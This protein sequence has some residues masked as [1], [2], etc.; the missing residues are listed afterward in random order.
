MR[1]GAIVSS[2]LHCFPHSLQYVKCAVG[3][4]FLVTVAQLPCRRVR[5]VCKKRLVSGRTAQMTLTH[6]GTNH[7]IDRVL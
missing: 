2:M 1:Y 4:F 7:D 3:L 6:F 5:T